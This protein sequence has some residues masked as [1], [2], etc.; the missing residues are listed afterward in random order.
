MRGTTFGTT[1]FAPARAE[2]AFVPAPSGPRCGTRRPSSP[3][4]V[5]LDPGAVAHGWATSE[6]EQ[7]RRVFDPL[8]Q[9]PALQAPGHV[10]QE[11]WLDTAQ[12]VPNTGSVKPPEAGQAQFSVVEYITGCVVQTVAASFHARHAA[13]SP[14]LYG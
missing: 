2:H 11:Y 13:E 8:R 14:V 10:E 6:P 7:L 3:R 4:E 9:V 1:N 5:R 12:Y